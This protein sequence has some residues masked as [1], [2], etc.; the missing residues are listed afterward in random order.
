LPRGDRAR[1]LF[2]VPEGD[3]YSR[4]LGILGNALPEMQCAGI[5]LSWSTG[6]EM[7]ARGIPFSHLP[8]RRQTSR[9]G[10]EIPM[11]AEHIAFRGGLDIPATANNALAQFRSE[12][13]REIVRYKPDIVIGGPIDHAAC[14][15]ADQ[16]AGDMGVLR[17]GLQP[18]HLGG[19]FIV[20]TEGT[21]WESRLRSAEIVNDKATEL[22]D[23]GAGPER[24]MR[25]VGHRLETFSASLWL[26][27]A[28]YALRALFGGASVHTPRSLLALA[29]ARVLPRKWLPDFPTL[30]TLESPLLSNGFVLVTLNQ[31][32]L[33]PD[34]IAWS[35]LIAFSLAAV[36]S[37]VAIVFRPHP[38]ESGRD[39]PDAIRA[40]LRT[41]NVWVSRG[42][43]GPSLTELV[44][45]CRGVL[46]LTSSVGIEGLLRSKPV[47]TLASALFARP[48]LARKVGLGDA[49]AVREA[50]GDPDKHRPSVSAVKQFVSWLAREHMAPWPELDSTGTR[51]VASLVRTCIASMGR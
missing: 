37:D 20:R 32:A 39:A 34:G 25:R 23:S 1:I 38:N 10:A 47:F 3:H 33:Q 31:P 7:R 11:L 27:G 49:M 18:C 24:G 15:F 48:G 44:E 50:L 21:A 2:A 9:A 22:N 13:E 26:R 6:R 46:T 42:K 14:Y 51:S 45:R 28:E 19:H 5:G 35:D 8:W 43:R 40:Q 29:R 4:Q 12:I 36:P 41:R 17:M 30:E 16:L